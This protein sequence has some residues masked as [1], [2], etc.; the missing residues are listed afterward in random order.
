[1]PRYAPRLWNLIPQS[2]WNVVKANDPTGKNRI[3]WIPQN[4]SYEREGG[5]IRQDWL[6]KLGLQMPKTQAEYLA[7]L[8]AFRDRDP[9]GNGIADEL[10]TGGR[11]GARWM[12]HL[13][14][15]YGIAMYEGYPDW[16]IY[17]GELTY[18]AVTQNAK[19]ALIFMN[20]LYTEKLIDPETFLN[21]KSGWE[22]KIHSGKAGNYFHWTL[23][24]Y[25]FL[26]NIHAGSG[27]QADI[28]VMP[29]IRV[30]GYEGKGFVTHKSMGNSAWVI[31]SRQDE[32][33]LMTCLKLLNE[34]ADQSK[35]T[36]LYF[37]VEGM[38]H[39][40]VNGKRARLPNNPSTQQMAFLTPSN[41]WGTLEY[42]VSD[43]EKAISEDNRWMYEQSIRN[44]RELQQYVRNIAGDGM[45]ETVYD[46][47]PEIKR[48][49][50]WQEYATKIII[51]T[52]PIS[53]FDEFVD[54]WNREGGAE[55]T[56]RAREWYARVAQ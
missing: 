18:S 48:C 56:R 46:D 17:N 14:N 23:T 30:P 11:Q 19:D 1:L 52:F 15:M 45:P 41:E 10:P 53:K 43:L 39:E 16:D 54:R 49:T 50:L 8:R 34:L 27:V 35:W 28:T 37:G 24:T 4:L 29:V 9:N 3:Y 21:D 22:G 20:Q 33:H 40:V 7:V 47:Y 44:I 42:A 31:S 13:F 2:T 32:A 5:Q 36:D 51:G 25:E 55:V 38:H 12:D 6:D 26:S